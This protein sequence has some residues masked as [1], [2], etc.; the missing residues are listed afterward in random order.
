MPANIPKLAVYLAA[1]EANSVFAPLWPMQKFSLAHLARHVHMCD[2]VDGGEVARVWRD[3]AG[4]L[5]RTVIRERDAGLSMDDEH[6]AMC[7]A[8]KAL[9]G[10]EDSAKTVTA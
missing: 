8:W 6:D 9:V 4:R 10:D 2:V 1:I 7:A 5:A 3:V